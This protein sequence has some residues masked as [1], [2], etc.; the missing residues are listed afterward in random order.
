MSSS[1]SLTEIKRPENN[2]RM[3]IF[4]HALLF[5]LGFSFVF[6][7]GWG[8]ATTLLGSLFSTY[9][10]IIAKIGGIVVILFGLSTSAR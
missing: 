7:V 10:P 9:K 1:I 8:G 3:T 5:V 4:L 6:I 2:Q